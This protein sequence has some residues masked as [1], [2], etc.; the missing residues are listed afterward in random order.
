MNISS[1]DYFYKQLVIAFGD[2]YFG[3]H[4]LFILIFLYSILNISQASVHVSV[5]QSMKADSVEHW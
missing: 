3:F 1:A 4:T 5:I 2:S